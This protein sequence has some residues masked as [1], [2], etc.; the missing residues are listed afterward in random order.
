MVKDSETQREPPGRGRRRRLWKVLVPLLAAAAIGAV[1]LT[2]PRRA[3]FYTDAD[4]IREPQSSA[5]LREV[6]WQPPLPLPDLPEM[7]EEVYEPRLSADGMT[8]FFVRGK[9]GGAADIF[10]C[11]RTARGWSDPHPLEG[12]NTEFDDLGPEPSSDGKA[13]YFYSDRPGG[14]GGYDL[15]VARRRGEAAGGYGEVTHLGPAVNS[16]CNEYGPALTADGR[17]LYFASNRPLPGDARQPDPDAWPGTIREDLFHRTYD[18]YAAT[19]TDAGARPAEAIT[20]INTAHN[21]GAP[22]VSPVGDFLYFA[23]DRPG[24]S[25]GFDLYRTRRL[26][27]EYQPPEN[28]GTTVNSTANELDPA[29][30]M[31]GYA[32]HFSSDRRPSPIAAEPPVAGRPPQRGADAE[33]AASVAAVP[34]VAAPDSPF[35]PAK[36]AAHGGGNLGGLEKR[37]YRLYQTASR[38]VFREVESQARSFDWAAL[39]S[40][41]AWNL[42]WALLALLLLLLMAALTRDLRGR[43]L[44]LL[45]RCLLASLAA[46][47]LLMLL[48]N[49]WQVTAALAGTLIRRGAVKVA[50]SAPTG[51]GQLVAQIRGGFTEDPSAPRVPASPAQPRWEERIADAADAARYAASTIATDLRPQP[52]RS[53]AEVLLAAARDAAPETPS[54]HVPRESEASRRMTLEIPVPS[55]SRQVA[56]PEADPR[57]AARIVVDAGAVR[58]PV[59]PASLPSFAESAPALLAPE[60]ATYELRAVGATVEDAPVREWIESPADAER[61][62]SAGIKLARL[63]LPAGPPPRAI[64]EAPSVPPAA[65]VQAP[66]PPRATQITLSAPRSTPARDEIEPLAE[67]ARRVAESLLA[68]SA[69]AGD[70]PVQ[71]AELGWV[72]TGEPSADRTSGL[73]RALPGLPLPSDSAAQPGAVA[74]APTAPVWELPAPPRAVLGLDVASVSATASAPTAASALADLPSEKAPGNAAPSAETLLPATDAPVSL[75]LGREKLHAAAPIEL[76]DIALPSETAAP[77]NPYPQRAADHRQEVVR[78]HGGSDA[79]EGAVSRALEWLA[80]HQSADGHWDGG[81]FDAECRRCGGETQVTV[82]AA[83]TGLSLLCFLA[84]DHTHTKDGPYRGQVQRGLRWLRERQ[85]PDGDLRGDETMYSQGIAAIALSEALGMTG[86]PA[87]RDP[88]RRAVRFIDR[89]R[90]TRGGGWRY[91]PGQPG[92]TSVLGWQ[93]MALKSAAQAGEEVPLEA[94]QAARRWLERVR[95]ADR[96]GLYAYQPGRP[97]TRAMTAEALFVRQLLAGQGSR[98]AEAQSSVEF[99][100]EELPAWPESV[101]TYLWYYATLAL[102]QHQGEAWER[103]NQAL[104]R[105]LLEH[106]R[107]DGPA[108]G[109]WDPIG[110]WAATGG[111][112]YQTAICALMLE[113]YYRYLPLYAREEAPAAIGALRGRVTDSDT[114]A[115]LSGAMVRLDVPD[116]PALTATSDETGEYRLPAPE[117]PDF[118]A[119]SAARDGYVPAT[120]NVSSATLRGSTVRVDFALRRVDASTIAVEAVPRVHHL[121]DDRFTGRINSRFQRA[122]EG[123]VFAAEFQVSADQLAPPPQGA[124]LHLLAK[125]VQRTHRIFINNTLLADTLSASPSDGSF[126]EFRA[127]FDAGLLTPGANTLVIVAGRL[128]DDIDDFE[129]VNVRIHLGPGPAA[130]TR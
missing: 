110:E 78:E 33:S 11:L 2:L 45:T 30:A 48:F 66:E 63:V 62:A 127:A 117:L 92:D 3:A 107:T 79:T 69:A 47:L 74:E 95:A 106:Q 22:A 123:R 113:V 77:P 52:T 100:L 129:F 20:A 41:A 9:A 96:P 44:S 55:E 124:A 28:L 109:S 27:G 99:L 70:A 14:M 25:G 89:A 1:W 64:D 57:D 81:G 56:E 83:L 34:G 101:N 50:L 23:S 39:W 119:L 87:L 68:Q 118:F 90:D 36:G 85:R 126:G 59:P 80:R 112:V 5:A 125:G 61:P 114:G 21:E 35:A 73:P 65:G 105:Q 32:L 130:G 29:P 76:P 24:G 12:V 91:D 116:R 38:E 46:H 43:R 98:D 103:W 51:A 97:C 54:A 7:D 111:R 8:L 13:L 26:R 42:L 75:P 102:F 15:W 84:A 94:M 120:A 58:A 10:C 17:T 122:A 53:T 71:P 6:L 115:V 37:R 19:I 121:G 104:T 16:P 108:A 88:V 31:G 18:L 4:T 86:D 72:P 128:G 49:A 40:G 67:S 60:P 82:D 93:V